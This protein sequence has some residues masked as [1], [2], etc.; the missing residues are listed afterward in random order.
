M[1]RHVP[2]F[3]LVLS[4]LLLVLTACNLGASPEQQQIAT[5]Q[6]TNAALATRTPLGTLNA[7]TTLPLTSLAPTVLPGQSRPT[8]IVSFPPTAVLPPVGQPQ[9]P[10]SI[11]ILSPISGNVIASNVQ[12]LGSA[13]HPQFLQ[14][15]LEYG[16]DPNPSN[17]WYPITGGIQNTVQN[18]LLGI[19]NTTG[20]QDGLYQLR[21]RVYLR[22]GTNLSTLVSA[23]RIQNRQPTPQPTA[24]QNIPRPIA[25]F[26]QDKT[27]GQA[28][29]R[30]NFTNQSSGN[31]TGYQW[32]FGDG[33]TSTER[34][35]SHVYRTANLYTVTLRVSG[36]GGSSNV[37]S[38][39]NVLSPTAPTAGFS[40]DRQSGPVPLT[41]RFSDQSTGRVTAYQWN[42]S[43]GGSSSDQNPVH[44]FNTPGTYNVLLSVSGPGGTSNTLRQVVVQGPTNTPPPTLTTV[45]TNTAVPTNVP[46]QPPTAD[47]EAALAGDLT[48]GFNDRSSSPNGNISGWAWDF[49]D[50]T[51][52]NEQNPTH[53]Y[54]SAGIKRITLTVTDQQNQ[55]SQAVAKDIEV[56]Q[57][58]PPAEPPSA[59][60][61]AAE[62]GALTFAFTDTSTPGTSPIVTWAWDFGDGTTSSDQNPTHTYAD[63]GSK[64]VNLTVGDSNGQTSSP[65]SAVIQVSAP[66]QPPTAG[67]TSA[68]AGDLIIS[69]QDTSTPGSSPIVTWSWDF[70][71]GT[72]SSDQNPTHT[73]ADAGSKNV[74]LTVIDSNGQA[75][76]PVSQAVQVDAPA[77]AP[78]AGFTSTVS[79]DLTISFQDT[80]TPG[81]S[82]I[83]TWV[84][85]FGDG[86]SGADQNPTHTYAEAGSKQVSL[87]VVD[88]NGQ[89]SAVFTQTVDVPA[90]QGGGG[91]QPGP[92]ILDETPALPD[93]SRNRLQNGINAIRSSANAQDKQLNVL[94]VAGDQTALDPAYLD[95]FNNT[96][97]YLLDTGDPLQ[98]IIDWYNS[99]DL[100]GYTSFNRTSVATGSDWRAADL[101]DPARRDTNQCSDGETP[102]ACEI[103]LMR[104]GV[105]I[106][107]V[108]MNDVT[109]NTDPAAFRASLEQI[110]QIAADQGVIPVLT[111]IQPRPDNVERTLEF[112]IIIAEVADQARIPL[113][114]QNAL[115]NSLPNSGLNGD[116]MTLSFGNPPGDITR[117]AQQTYGMS[118][119]N[120]GMLTL[121]YNLKQTFFP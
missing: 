3:G 19:W 57:P 37:S 107:S 24:T 73:Y 39:I 52:S 118:S 121:L 50:G 13:I 82:P 5:N 109:A 51:T 62:T 28:P 47:F 58:P 2:V 95:P 78:T 115:L 117:A 48:V 17:L 23:V 69:F 102:L 44:V 11:V 98:S 65:F 96:N 10:V 114:Y 116:N 64:T 4:V 34:N 1:K 36:P 6:G 54:S 16:P 20:V 22:D 81:S 104:P 90:P 112:N 53:V 106:I 76:A 97:Q 40:M 18:N 66:A 33:E 84:W 94:T 25:A 32:N 26:T 61:T 101:L 75:S 68:A 43:D 29:M 103:R 21:L 70:G 15:Q 93:F 119:R 110:V 35:P 74:T 55:T 63:A 79:A 91:Q 113:F 120:W 111:T 86:S 9:V 60:F 80:S 59:Q 7:P 99:T 31:I 105:I 56:P 92:N 12:V 108:G 83:A 67:F 77:Q 41:V 100:G 46:L 49:G 45:P 71:D 89:A 72:T 85:D 30:V 27:S 38:Q 42:F 8:A 87:T 14:Y 88:S